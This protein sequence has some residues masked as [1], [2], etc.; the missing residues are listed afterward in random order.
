MRVFSRNE[1]ILQD[2]M[3]GDEI[4]DE[5][6]G[7]VNHGCPDLTGNENPVVEL[8]QPGFVYLESPEIFRLLYNKVQRNCSI[9][10]LPE[11]YWNR[12]LTILYAKTGQF[13]RI[14]DM[15]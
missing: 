9:V 6:K 1:N 15:S 2:Q 5:W 11:T 3:L 8:C 10:Q 13:R 12:K 7:L 14:V 4:K